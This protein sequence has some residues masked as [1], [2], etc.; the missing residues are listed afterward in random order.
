MQKNQ[1]TK[2]DKYSWQWFLYTYFDQIQNFIHSPSEIMRSSEAP[3]LLQE[4]KV[5][6]IWTNFVQFIYISPEACTHATESTERPRNGQA[7]GFIA[8]F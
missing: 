6:R 5:A 1:K 2:I 8:N 4:R 3:K 7:V